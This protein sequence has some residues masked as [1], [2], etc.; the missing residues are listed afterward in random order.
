MNAIQL[1]SGHKLTD[2]R[3]LLELH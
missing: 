2:R 1:P 3:E